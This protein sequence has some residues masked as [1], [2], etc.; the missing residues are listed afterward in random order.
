MGGGRG[1]RL[2]IQKRKGMFHEAGGQ[3]TFGK[4][5]MER[6]VKGILGSK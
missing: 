3:K 1:G 5:T 2:Q 6:G 4:V